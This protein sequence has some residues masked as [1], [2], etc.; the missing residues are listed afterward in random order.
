MTFSLRHVALALSLS[1]TLA[2]SVAEASD[3]EPA[4]F[5]VGDSHVQ[6]LGPTLTHRL[7]E[8]GVRVAG[9]EARPGW[10]TQRYRR[11]GDLTD[12]LEGAGRPE[13]VVVSLGG[14]DFV[15]SPE[16][17]YAQ[18]SWVVD[19]ARAAGAR[20]I[21]W[22]GPA[23]SDVEAG[24]RA[25]EVGARHERN[26]NL[27]AEL[28]PALGVTWIDSRPMTTEHHGRDGIHFTRSGY[29][30]WARGALPS[31]TDA[32]AQERPSGID[33]DAVAQQRSPGMEEDE[34]ASA[35]A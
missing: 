1:L 17:Y 20:E 4:V 9:Y 31:V 25:A 21:I 16:T 19:H 2:S 32:I 6:M 11:A 14:N 26:A 22:L 8:R 27:Q 15:G 13:I 5:V 3:T 18:L 33:A 10:S 7:E 35:R 24:E 28:L 12:V 23:T 30:D 34:L 29:S